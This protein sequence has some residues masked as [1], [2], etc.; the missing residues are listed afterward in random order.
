MG[1]QESENIRKD[2]FDAKLVI[3]SAEALHLRGWGLVLEMECIG[4]V[5]KIFGVERDAVKNEK[6]LQS[7]I[8]F[9]YPSLFGYDGGKGFP[10]PDVV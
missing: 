3:C 4:G 8:F 7:P 10:E 2:E 6:L 9:Q 5:L 1:K